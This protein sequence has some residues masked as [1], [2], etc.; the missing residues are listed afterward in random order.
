MPPATETAGGFAE[1]ITACRVEVEDARAALQLAIAR[2]N[3][4]LVDAVDAGMTQRKAA[5]LGGI[6]APYLVSIIAHSY[7]SSG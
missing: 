6:A 3:E 7:A 2:R 5:Q 4:T 1:R